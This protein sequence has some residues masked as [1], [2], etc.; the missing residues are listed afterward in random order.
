MNRHAAQRF[1]AI[2]PFTSQF[3]VHFLCFEGKLTDKAWNWKN[4][5]QAL[6]ESCMEPKFFPQ[7]P[8]E[9]E[10]TAQLKKVIMLHR[11]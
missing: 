8:S 4:F 7:L 11:S 3:P 2:L 10:H 9:F 5:L 1:L 6:Q